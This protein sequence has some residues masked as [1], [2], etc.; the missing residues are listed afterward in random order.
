MGTGGGSLPFPV[1][2]VLVVVILVVGLMIRR[3]TRK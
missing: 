1:W 3:S 2:L